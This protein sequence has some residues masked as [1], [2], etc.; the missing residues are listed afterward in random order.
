MRKEDTF[1][2]KLG[3]KNTHAA[4]EALQVPWVACNQENHPL[5]V[6]DIVD[7][8]K[9][10][11]NEDGKYKKSRHHAGV[12]QF[13]EGRHRERR[14]CSDHDQRLSIKLAKYALKGWLDL[15]LRTVILHW[16]RASESSISKKWRDRPSDPTSHEYIQEGRRRTM[17]LIVMPMKV[18]RRN[19]VSIRAFL[20]TA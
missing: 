17:E 10:A 5:D 11:K 4:R 3:N 1:K 14:F 15:G 16:T 2:K 6:K 8:Y 9:N 13:S 20:C 18:L 7:D 12:P 19:N